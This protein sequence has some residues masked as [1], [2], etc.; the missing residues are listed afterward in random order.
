ML[1]ADQSIRISNVVY[2]FRRR[3]FD[4][5]NN[6]LLSESVEVIYVEKKKFH[7]TAFVNS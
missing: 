7:N 5:G 1:D 3:W 2:S 6:L 4:V